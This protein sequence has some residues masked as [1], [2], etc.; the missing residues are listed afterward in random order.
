MSEIPI[1]TLKEKL[2]DRK[3]R[4]NNLYFVK[5]EHGKKVQFKMNPIQEFLHDNLWYFNIVPKA[6]QLGISTFFCILYFDQVLF[7]EN[8][9]AAIICHKQEDA[10]KFF[11][12]KIKFAWENL[13]PWLRNK[14]G[15]PN[16]DSA[17]E[18][19][20]TNCS[21]ISVA[22]STRSGTVQLL[23]ISEFGYI[24]QHFPEKAEEIVSGAINS[25]HAGCMVS[26]ESTA[27]GREGYFYEFCMQAERNRK[28]A[29]SL[30]ELDWKIF[31]FPWYLDERYQLPTADF[32]IADEYHKYFDQ[33]EQ[34]YKIILTNAQKRWW[35]KKKE[36][37]KDKMFAEFP[38]TLDE[39]FSVS[40]EGAYYAK[41]MARVYSSRR[42]Q[43]LPAVSNSP[44][45]VWW[46]LG[47]NDFM[48]LIFVQTVG[49]TIRFVDLYYNHGEGLE[50]YAKVLE[51]K[52]Y[53]YG[54]FVLPHDINVK[55]MSTG[56]TRKQKLYELGITNVQVA[57][58][59]KIEDGIEIVRG[60]FRR[61][62]FDEE[63]TLKLYEALGNYRKEWDNKLGVFKDQPRHDENSHFC[64]AI[65]TG[66][67]VW[68]EESNLGSDEEYDS[69]SKDQAFFS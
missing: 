38:S 65:R 34:R 21:S 16:T 23:H 18:L 40:M 61:F 43:I 45:D 56:K 17:G 13:H 63:K 39:A 19:V 52:G 37:N 5:D 64:D 41:E 60:L 49:A 30:T 26:I 4:I 68:R 69:D 6:R 29:R 12:N 58:K 9:T 36:T 62:Y 66:A 7:S 24:C 50:H 31:F 3:W 35:V 55:D 67:S 44:I 46:D 14:I 48:V 15:E 11:R 2:G 47:V 27:A 22:T 25:V 57:P 53:R 59:L 33:L 51:E 54:K 20:F 42:I 8:R 10:K 32:I 1:E 28:E